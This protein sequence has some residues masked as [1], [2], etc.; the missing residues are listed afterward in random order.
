MLIEWYNCIELIWGSSPSDYLY[1][2]QSYFAQVRSD[3]VDDL[4]DN[5]PSPVKHYDQ[6][7]DWEDDGDD[8]G[9][10][11]DYEYGDDHDGDDHY[12]DVDDLVDNYPS[13]VKHYDQ[14]V[15]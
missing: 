3:Y 12:G 11:Y 8:D 6:V 5:Y 14:V 7:V 2:L 4:V 15:D 1:I 9:H 13:P 10:D